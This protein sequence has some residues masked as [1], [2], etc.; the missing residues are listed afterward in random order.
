MNQS[1][2]IK[3]KGSQ[4]ISFGSIHTSSLHTLIVDSEFFRNTA[5]SGAGISLRDASV[6]IPIRLFLKLDPSNQQRLSLIHSYLYT[7]AL[8]LT[9]QLRVGVVFVLDLAVLKSPTLK[10]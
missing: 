7:I 3:N 1:H 5:W 2:F 8:L 10:S 6:N 4:S 9:I